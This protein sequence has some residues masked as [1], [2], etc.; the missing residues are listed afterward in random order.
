M[1][2]KQGLAPRSKILL[3]PR[4]RTWARAGPHHD[5]LLVVADRGDRGL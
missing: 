1:I 4:K 5:A 2:E 3:K